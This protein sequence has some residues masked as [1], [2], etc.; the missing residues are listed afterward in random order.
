MEM[1]KILSN[2]RAYAEFFKH[3][4]SFFFSHWLVRPSLREMPLPINFPAIGYVN[5]LYPP[6][7]SIM[8]Q[9]EEYTLLDPLHTCLG[10]VTTSCD[11]I[12]ARIPLLSVQASS[13]TVLECLTPYVQK[14][15]QPI[16]IEHGVMM[17]ILGKGVLILGPSGSGK[18]QAAFNLLARGHRLISDDCVS[19]YRVCAF[20]VKAY[21]DPRLKNLLEIRGLGVI[22][23]R[24]WYGP[25]STLAEKT[26]DLV[27][28]LDPKQADRRPLKKELDEKIILGVSLPHLTLAL[29]FKRDLAMLIESA[30]K[31]AFCPSS[32]EIDN[33]LHPA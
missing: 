24:Q 33:L 21:A 12:P 17:D 18:S 4:Q 1:E 16:H 30:V 2:P 13:S 22:D 25:C 26:I 19:C 15:F 20:E 32:M 27:I 9:S 8:T 23:V 6:L 5:P 31:F 7:I 3:C 10:I 29:D 28:T 14:H 11:N